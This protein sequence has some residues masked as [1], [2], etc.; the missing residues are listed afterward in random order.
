MRLIEIG[1]KTF[2]PEAVDSIVPGTREG[3]TYITLRGG[4]SNIV[5]VPYGKVRAHLAW[6]GLLTVGHSAD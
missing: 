1:G 2:N 6:E 4:S 5:D 3:T